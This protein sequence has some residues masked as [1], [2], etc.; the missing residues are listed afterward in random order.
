MRMTISFKLMTMKDTHSG[1]VSGRIPEDWNKSSLVSIYKGK[2]DAM[3]SGSYRGIK[4]LDQA[5]KVMEL[6]MERQIRDNVKIDEMQFRFSKGKGKTDAIFI[7]RQLQEK[8]LGL[9][10]E[11]W[12][13]FEDLEKVSTECREKFC[14]EPQGSWGWMS[15]L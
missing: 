15:G 4:L 1:C 11:L 8:Y 6:V 5:M 13:A 14:G 7:V 2:G 10:R 12:I 9:R 3:D